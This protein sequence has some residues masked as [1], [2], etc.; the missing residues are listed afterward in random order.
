MSERRIYRVTSLGRPVEPKYPTNKAILVLMLLAALVA[1][2]VALAQGVVFEG[3]VARALSALML[4]F[5]CWALGRE[6]SPDDNAAAFI[7]TALAVIGWWWWPLPSLLLL[8]SALALS[9]VVNR[10]TG[11]TARR[12]D[13][14]IVTALVI[15]TMVDLQNPL[16][17][18]AAAT[19]FVFD[20]RLADPKRSQWLFA[21]LCLAAVG[22]QMRVIAKANLA[23]TFPLTLQYV[24]TAAI[25][26]AFL[27]MAFSLR[28]V[29]SVGDVGARALDPSRVRGGMLVVWLLALATILPERSGLE[30]A[31]PMLAVMAGVV[32]SAVI[33]TVGN[34]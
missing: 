21:A 29:S 17:G 9:R 8:F 27:A 14:L 12:S 13:S 22:I 25:L 19:A 20:A 7:G 4:V 5:V 1:G 33:N 6:L 34:R 24:A 10:S 11:L 30:M 16:L 28:T 26:L 3:S 31:L 18:L 15:W 2:L 32:L 23:V